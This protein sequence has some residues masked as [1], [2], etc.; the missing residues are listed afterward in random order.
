[1][2]TAE[3]ETDPTTTPT[4]EEEIYETMKWPQKKDSP[5]DTTISDPDSVTDISRIPKA[6]N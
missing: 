3:Q 5:L 4:T 1:M 2:S 6:V